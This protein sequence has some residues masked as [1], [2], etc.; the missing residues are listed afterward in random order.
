MDGCALD[1]R[2]FVCVRVGVY[3]CALRACTLET[4]RV[5]PPNPRKSEVKLTWKN[6]LEFQ[7]LG[8]IARVLDPS[9]LPG[10]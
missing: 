8:D 1:V 6:N 2:M 5:D 10:Q 9:R 4:L 3:A 7:R